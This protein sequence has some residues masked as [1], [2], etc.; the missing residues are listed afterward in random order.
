MRVFRNRA[1]RARRAGWSSRGRIEDATKRRAC[2]G[3]PSMAA[4]S[5]SADIGRAVRN[6]RINAVAGSK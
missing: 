6:P 1:V 2:N 3:I 4:S 5:F